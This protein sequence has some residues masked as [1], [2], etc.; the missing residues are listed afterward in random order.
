MSDV[1]ICYDKNCE[2]SGCGREWSTHIGCFELY[3]SFLG[4]EWRKEGKV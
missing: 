3:F 1:H 4:I 2:E